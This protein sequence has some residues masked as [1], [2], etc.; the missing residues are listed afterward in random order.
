[1]SST[2]RINDRPSGSRRFENLS[3]N[4]IVRIENNQ[5]YKG[6]K[7]VFHALT[8]IIRLTQG[9]LLATLSICS[10]EGYSETQYLCNIESSIVDEIS[11]S[12]F[13]YIRIIGFTNMAFEAIHGIAERCFSGYT[14]IE[15]PIATTFDTIAPRGL[16]FIASLIVVSN[17]HPDNRIIG[18]EFVVSMRDLVLF[19]RLCA[20]RDHG[21]SETKNLKHA[22]TALY[23]ARCICIILGAIYDMQSNDDAKCKGSKVGFT[24]Q[25][26]SVMLLAIEQSYN[27]SKRKDEANVHQIPTD[28]QRLINRPDL[29]NNRVNNIETGS[30]INATIQ[31][32]KDLGFVDFLNKT[33]VLE[34]LKEMDPNT[35]AHVL[36]I[37]KM[38]QDNIDQI[39][40]ISS[41]LPVV[42]KE[43]LEKF[44]SDVRVKA[45]LSERQVDGLKDLNLIR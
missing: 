7:P 45:S 39:T 31:S 13:S 26:L 15:N 5:V 37:K 30:E 22:L 40:D 42:F 6:L 23:A 36:H 16:S 43:S 25:V 34:E 44:L 14:A 2:S 29:G 41:P 8:P 27:T 38:L 28:R 4:I 21:N 9:E 19:G 17:D 1:M 10:M 11:D 3:N 12:L 33:E 18:A 35:Q 24:V 20:I 32:L